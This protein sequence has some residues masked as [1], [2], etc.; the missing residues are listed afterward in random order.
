MI[1]QKSC[2]LTQSLPFTG[3]S[4]S[5]DSRALPHTALPSAP[6]PASQPCPSVQVLVHPS[7]LAAMLNGRGLGL[8]FKLM[9]CMLDLA[10][11]AA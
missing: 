1:Y 8:S 2:S 6:A 3:Q 5:L 4:C 11:R 9:L 10:S 7:V